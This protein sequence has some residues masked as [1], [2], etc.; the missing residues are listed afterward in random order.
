[1]VYRC[2]PSQPLADEANVAQRPPRSLGPRRRRGQRWPG[3][4]AGPGWLL[5]RAGPG[6][7]ANRTVG[8]RDPVRRAVPQPERSLL[9]MDA[10]RRRDPAVARDA[11]PDEARRSADG[12]DDRRLDP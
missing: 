12:A 11:R 9:L 3:P 2:D 10:V 7:A 6:G 1:M 4:A 5:R 8:G